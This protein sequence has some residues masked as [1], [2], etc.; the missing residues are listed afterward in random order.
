MNAPT[1][2]L[3][4]V[5]GAE[6]QEHTA[7]LIEEYAQDLV[8]ARAIPAEQAREDALKSMER[9]LPDG[10]ATEGQLIR[11]AEDAGRPV[12]WI[13]IALPSA[14]ERPDT[15]YV[16]DLEVDARQRGRGYGRAIMLAAEAELIRLGIPR[17]A[18]NV[19][20]HNPVA[21]RLYESL[22]FQTTAQQMA[23]SLPGGSPA[24]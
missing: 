20:G 9:L 12:G 13:W 8:Q 16:Y 7:R 24:G 23:K 3:R 18:L 19:F 2:V 1:V 17:L 21:I 6:F 15:A 10:I 5:T 22:G 11:I 14:P 4:P